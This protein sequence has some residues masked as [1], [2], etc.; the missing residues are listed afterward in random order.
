MKKISEIKEEDIWTDRHLLY[1]INKRIK[2]INTIL[3][4]IEQKLEEKR[5]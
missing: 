2:D 1:E 5:K 3:E 4:Y